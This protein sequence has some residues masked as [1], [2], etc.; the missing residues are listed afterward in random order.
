MGREG[1]KLN[2]RLIGVKN[3][4]S[5]MSGYDGGSKP[6]PFF[7]INIVIFIF[8]PLSAAARDRNDNIFKNNME[9]FLLDF[10]LGIRNTLRK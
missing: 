5:R 10:H 9:F 6:T 7:Q 1:G 4:S 8:F 2:L 3:G